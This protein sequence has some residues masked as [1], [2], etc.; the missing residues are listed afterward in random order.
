MVVKL[1]LKG[2]GKQ[3]A[4]P[5]PAIAYCMHRQICFDLLSR[6]QEQADV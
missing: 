6:S 3:R 1:G 2:E 5:V 4:V